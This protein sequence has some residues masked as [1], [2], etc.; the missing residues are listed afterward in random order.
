MSKSLSIFK[1]AFLALV[2]AVPMMFMFAACDELDTKASCAKSSSYSESNM[3]AL[4]EAIGETTPEFAEGYRMTMQITMDMSNIPDIFGT[5]GDDDNADAA[6]T[7]NAKTETKME[8][9]INAIVTKDKIALK[10]TGK[11]QD[12]KD[13]TMS[14]Y[15][16]DGKIYMFD[17]AEKTKLYVELD[18]SQQTDIFAALQEVLEFDLSDCGLDEILANIR[19]AD[20]VVVSKDGNRF[21]AE[22]KATA[23]ATEASSTLY[24]NFNNEGK[25]EAFET[26]VDLFGVIKANVVMSAYKG[27]VSL[28]NFSD[29]KQVESFK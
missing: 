6:G 10:L 16:A 24:I 23:D 8:A 13:Q 4:E 28:P 15:V 5:F 9:T 17:S 25:L 7:T 26:T 18:A 1:N 14:V 27:N 3:A 12:G 20:N 19:T 21:K 2:L 11:D 29:Y 22:V